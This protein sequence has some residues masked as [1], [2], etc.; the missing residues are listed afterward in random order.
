MKFKRFSEIELSK[1]FLLLCLLR[2]PTFGS[3][4]IFGNDSS[5][6]GEVLLRVMGGP[7]TAVSSICRE[8]S[9]MYLQALSNFTPWAINSKC[10]Q[11]VSFIQLS[12]RCELKKTNKMNMILPE[13]YI[14]IWA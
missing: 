13:Q 4:E 6:V 10:L 11:Q 5:S 8:H 14:F 2:N 1:L 7:F 9:Q 12:H 3:A